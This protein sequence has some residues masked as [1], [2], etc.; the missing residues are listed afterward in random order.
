MIL[1]RCSAQHDQTFVATLL[2]LMLAGSLGGFM[3]LLQRIQ[4]TP[5]GVDPLISILEVQDGKF[6]LYLA[7]ISGAVFAVLLYLIF[8]GRLV[9]GSIFPQDLPPFHL[10][11][12]PVEWVGALPT[13]EI[14]A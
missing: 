3:S 10:S 5:T 7:P 12:G 11:L 9:S 13:A 8:L 6:S 14:Y 1:E 2:I 4:N